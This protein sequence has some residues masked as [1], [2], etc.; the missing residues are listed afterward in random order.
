MTADSHNVY[1]SFI[2]SGSI[3]GYT[4][5]IAKINASTGQ[6]D[7]SFNPTFERGV[8]PMSGEVHSIAIKLG[9]P[10]TL[11]VGGAFNRVNTAS[12]G[13]YR[14]HLAEI[15]TIN[16]QALPFNPTGT[17]LDTN[18]YL[19]LVRYDPL[20]GIVYVTG[21]FS[22]FGGQSRNGLASILLTPSPNIMSF[23]PTIAGTITNIE[24]FNFQVYLSGSITSVNG[25]PRKNAAA[26]DSY[27][28]LLTWDP[29]PSGT[30]MVIRLSGPAASAQLFMGGGFSHIHAV[31]RANLVELDTNTGDPTSF[32]PSANGPV[33]AIQLKGSE[34]LVGGAFTLIGEGSKRS[35][36]SINLTTGLANA[37][38]AGITAGGEVTTLKSEGGKLYLGGSFSLT[39]G[40]S[41]RNNLARFD[42]ST[43]SLDAWAPQPDSL[44]S[45]FL[46][47]GGQVFVGGYFLNIGGSARKYL[48]VVDGTT[49]TAGTWNPNP[50]GYPEVLHA[51]NGELLVGGSF[52]QISGSLRSFLASFDLS[53]L[54]LNPWA[55]N[56]SHKV[57]DIKAYRGSLL[58]TGE[59]KSV[60]L[61]PRPGIMKIDAVNKNLDSFAPSICTSNI[62]Y[63]L[64]NK[65]LV[66]T[67]QLYVLGTVFCIGDQIRT[68][69]IGFNLQTGTLRP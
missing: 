11:F 18:A 49:G 28:G 45:S 44:V 51:G 67:T 47:Y 36:A 64:N 24:P 16:G 20:V 14:S 12:G 8:T 57:T 48:A 29:R 23:N 19:D 63:G 26:V 59:F 38:D 21:P 58:I 54:T 40:G 4:R 53:N 66:Y 17:L 65:L 25:Q 50:N 55:L 37:F 22:K 34:L 46:P 68:G 6:V 42:E 31:D 41:T 33:N 62:D 43:G 10:S 39:K 9:S 13:P 32:D 2:G 52:S 61:T 27:G 60:D 35:Y 3:N 1:L 15:S 7:P 5:Q 69:N 30:T 56:F